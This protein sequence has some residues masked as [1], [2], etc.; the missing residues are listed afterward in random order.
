MIDVNGIDTRKEHN[1]KSKKQHIRTIS[2]KIDLIF[3]S[4]L[5]HAYLL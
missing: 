1:N 2:I 3:L 5:S 4:S